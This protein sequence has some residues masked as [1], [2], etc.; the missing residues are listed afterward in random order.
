MSRSVLLSFVRTCHRAY[1]LFLFLPPCFSRIGLMLVDL[2]VYHQAIIWIWINVLVCDT[3]IATLVKLGKQ[4]LEVGTKLV[5]VR[6]HGLLLSVKFRGDYCSPSCS[7]VFFRFCCW[8]YLR[9]SCVLPQ[10]SRGCS[11]R[12]WRSY[13]R[14]CWTSGFRS[15][16]CGPSWC[17][18]GRSSG[19]IFRLEVTLFNCFLHSGNTLDHLIQH[20]TATGFLDYALSFCAAALSTVACPVV[21]ALLLLRKKM[22]WVVKTR[23]VLCIYTKVLIKVY[24]YCILPPPYPT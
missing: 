23:A 18:I 1:S 3:V 2:P 15:K 4:G 14:R 8:C 10:S 9:F 19:G 12:D 20:F 5:P 13:F 22:L 16:T 24:S 11:T 7:F 6:S 17:R 21:L